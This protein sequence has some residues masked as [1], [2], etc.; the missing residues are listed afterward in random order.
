MREGENLLR[1]DGGCWQE[2]ASFCGNTK[3]DIS[4]RPKRTFLFGNDTVYALHEVN[5]VANKLSSCDLNG[6]CGSNDNKD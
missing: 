5:L 3:K 2:I 6:L 1:I 4:L